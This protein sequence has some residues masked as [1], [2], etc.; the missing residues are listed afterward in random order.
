MT[1][2]SEI[3]EVIPAVL[4]ALLIVSLWVF[5]MNAIAPDLFQ[6][7]CTIEVIE[8]EK[9]V[10]GPMVKVPVPV[11]LPIPVP[12]VERQWCALSFAAQEVRCVDADGDIVVMK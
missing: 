7:K 11:P 1:F 10:P 3:K 2:L 8:V 9:E 4:V 12:V 5:A 6:N